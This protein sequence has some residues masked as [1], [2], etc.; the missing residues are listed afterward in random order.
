[1]NLTLYNNLSCYDSIDS[2]STRFTDFVNFIILPII[3]TCSFFTNLVC[4]IVFLNKKLKGETNQ[5]LLLISLA[6]FLGSIFRAAIMQARCGI[7]CTIGHS[8]PMKFYELYIFILTGNIRITFVIILYNFLALIKLLAFS[9][10]IRKNSF[11]IR[12]NKKEIFIVLLISTLV[13]LPYVFT[14]KI[15]HFGYLNI[16]NSTNYVIDL[17]PLYRI[18][19]TIDKKSIFDQLLFALTLIKGLLMI[20]ILLMINVVAFIRLK[21]Y[22]RQKMSKNI[23]SK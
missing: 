20:I 14:R 19:S 2:L 21:L 23:Q 16:R 18:E 5:I 11:S 8:Y 7:Y 13:N 22:L 3:N 6:D 4:V 15:T 12:K 17:Q 10:K 1:M 9:T